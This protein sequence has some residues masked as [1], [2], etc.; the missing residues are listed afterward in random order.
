MGLLRRQPSVVPSVKNRE[1]AAA[2]NKDVRA[3]EQMLGEVLSPGEVIKTYFDCPP[4][5][6]MGQRYFVLSNLH[7]FYL[8]EDREEV[9][10]FP[11]EALVG[12]RMRAGY[13]RMAF[14]GQEGVGLVTG[15]V[16]GGAH[17]QIALYAALVAAWKAITGRP[18]PKDEIVDS[19]HVPPFE[20][21]DETQFRKHP[22][23]RH[24][25]LFVRGHQ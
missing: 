16:G 25:R 21:A 14:E 23:Q 5:D 2:L 17:Q 15:F 11:I 10:A 24:P 9:F 1:M 22:R 8:Y 20:F 7:V 19:C 3:F 13:V 18:F 12:Y 4:R 6:G